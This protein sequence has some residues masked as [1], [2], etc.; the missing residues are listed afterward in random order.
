MINKIEKTQAKA[1]EKE[2]LSPNFKRN[3]LMSS[4]DLK[5]VFTKKKKP[6]NNKKK[7]LQSSLYIKGTNCLSFSFKKKNKKQRNRSFD[8]NGSFKKK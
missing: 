4:P 3:K 1:A 8:Y 7:D 5:F 2:Y 6:K